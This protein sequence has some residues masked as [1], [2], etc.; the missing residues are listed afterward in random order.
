MA[1]PINGVCYFRKDAFGD[2]VLIEDRVEI[3]KV[4]KHTL[5]HDFC[6]M[7]ELYT[8]HYEVLQ[9]LRKTTV[10]STYVRL[11]EMKVMFETEINRRLSV[12]KN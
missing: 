12:A 3:M 6:D 8:L 5:S 2:Y 4:G 9:C 11:H 7:I 10:R 1:F